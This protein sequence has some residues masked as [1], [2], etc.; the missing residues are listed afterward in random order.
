MALLSTMPSMAGT[1]SGLSTSPSLAARPCTL[2]AKSSKFR[3]IRR[4]AASASPDAMASSGLQAEGNEWQ[5]LILSTEEVNLPA[6]PAED[7]LLKVSVPH[8]CRK[9][10]PKIPPSRIHSDAD[11]ALAKPPGLHLRPPPGL[12]RQ[13]EAS[14]L[15]SSQDLCSFLGLGLTLPPHLAPF[16]AL[17][18][19]AS[20]EQVECLA[21]GQVEAEEEG[22][23]KD[24]AEEVVAKSTSE[25]TGCS[26]KTTAHLQ[27]PLPVLLGSRPRSSLLGS[28]PLYGK[29]AKVG[30]S[31]G[32]SR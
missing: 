7:E 18:T 16:A 30:E 20:T 3:Q 11:G 28:T 21:M 29:Q 17:S 25:L 9:P 19:A 13:T 22:A 10:V 1:N 6:C 2:P 32:A 26:A 4:A 15:P 14:A 23:Q 24:E 31:Q 5:G 8:F 12:T 27:P